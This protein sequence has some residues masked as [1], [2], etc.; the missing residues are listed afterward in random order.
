VPANRRHALWPLAPSSPPLAQ[1]E[2]TDDVVRDRVTGLSWTRK[3]TVPASF[4][5]AGLEAYCDGL[6]LG[7]FDDWRIPTRIEQL[8][9]FDFTVPFGFANKNV[10]TLDTQN[11]EAWWTSSED[12]F[13]TTSWTRFTVDPFTGNV[14]VSLSA[15]V[16]RRGR[17]V[18]GGPSVM[19]AERLVL[20]PSGETVIDRAT[21]L[22]WQRTV[23]N[24]MT[25]DDAK[26]AC[27]RLYLAGH[28]DFVLP[29]ARELLSLVDET[30]SAYPRLDPLFEVGAPRRFFSA[31]MR[32]NPA[33]MVWSV[34][35]D[36]A[37]LVLED[38]AGRAAVRCVRR[39]P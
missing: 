7:G 22:E 24:T 21:K 20:G 35:V 34:D 12:A 29:D 4:E 33:T 23:P 11:R 26:A 39:L 38:P 28:D 30:R 3:D 10:F 8:S 32:A 15:A 19:P 14:S 17:C 37:G 5:Y 1:Y 13:S 25:F 27:G 9:T 31:T 18:R 2:L 6:A 36:T 16:G